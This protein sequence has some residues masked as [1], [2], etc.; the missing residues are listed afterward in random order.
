MANTLTYLI[1]DAIAG[2]EIV[3]REMV[4]FIP[5]VTVAASQERAAK[6]QAVRSPVGCTQTFGSITPAA[7]PPA[8]S[9]QIDTYRTITMSNLYG[10][11]WYYTRE[12]EKGLAGSGA[13]PS[14]FSQ[15]VAQAY[16]AATIAIDGAIAALYYNASR[17]YG[18]AGTAPFASDLSA[19][20]ACETM[21]DV[22]GAPGDRHCIFSS[23]AAYNLLKL[24]QNTN[25]NQAGTDETLRRASFPDLMGFK[26]SRS[27]GVK[28][29]TC[30]AQTGENVYGATDGTV[31]VGATS[32]PYH[33]GNS[34]TALIGDLIYFTG[35]TDAPDGT[36]SKYVQ[37]ATIAHEEAA[38][39]IAIN[40]PGLLTAQVDTDEIIRVNTGNSLNATYRA[41]LCF[42]RDALVLAARPPMGN[43]AAVDEQLLTDPKSGLTFRLAEYRGYHGN[44]FE[45][46]ILYGVGTGNSEHMVILV[47]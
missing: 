40:S 41:N 31:A 7:T 4:G 45:L 21:L 20:G 13:Y 44:Q 34:G 35:A 22:N 47:G 8:F 32:I 18:T 9:D 24:T 6:G 1:P 15:K 42:S 39:T 2:I 27:G 25:V 33:G 14:L 38:G 23:K 37:N 29:H 16:R 17:A 19:L 12:E 30:G 11:R 5:A 10:S 28:L 46:S 3:S 26:M 36:P 43:D